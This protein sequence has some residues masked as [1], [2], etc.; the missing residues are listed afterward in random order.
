MQKVADARYFQEM[1]SKIKTDRWVQQN[2]PEESRWVQQP[3][4]FS[5]LKK[6]LLLI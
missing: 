2:A 4:R 1:N 6:L 5:I 3:K